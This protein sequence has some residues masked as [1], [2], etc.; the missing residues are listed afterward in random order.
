MNGKSFTLTSRGMQRDGRV[1]GQVCNYPCGATKHYKHLGV[2]HPYGS[3]LTVNLPYLLD[4]NKIV[5]LVF[6]KLYACLSVVH[7]CS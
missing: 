2:V 6:L 1:V 4:S 5:Y 3:L 7:R